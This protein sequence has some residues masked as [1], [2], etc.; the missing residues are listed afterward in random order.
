MSSGGNQVR[1]VKLMI[2]HGLIINKSIIERAYFLN[3]TQEIVEFL[4][5]LRPDLA[6]IISGKVLN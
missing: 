2:D 5:D 1:V 3:V 6:C 4:I